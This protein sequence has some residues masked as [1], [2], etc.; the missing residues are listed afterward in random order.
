MFN[1]LLDQLNELRAK[2]NLS[3]PGSFEGLHKEVRGLFPVNF[4][5]DGAKFEL[6]S[7]HNRNFQTTHSF[8]WGSAQTPAGYHFGAMFA[9]NS[10]IM[11]G[12]VDNNGTLQARGHYNWIDLP[13]PAFPAHEDGP[14]VPN[15][16]DAP[17]VQSTSKLQ[18]QLTT[19]PGQSAI[20]LEHDH[21]GID[22]SIS[23]KAVN[24][25]P[26][27]VPS[28]SS[29]GTPTITGVFSLNYLQ[30]ISKS[31]SLGA[32][33][34]L[35]R[36]YP[37]MSE[38]ATSFALRYAPP[39]QVLPK[40][41]SLPDSITESP[42]M[43]INPSDPTE[44]ATATYSPSSG[45]AHLSYWRRLNQRLEVG[46]ELQMLLTPQSKGARRE[47][48]ATV[49][50]KFDTV[51]ATIRS[52]VETTGRVTTVLEEKIS[53]GISFQLNGEIDYAKGSAGRVGFG[54]TFEQ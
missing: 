44:V 39:A 31:F 5:I 47:A 53:P 3:Q 4:V 23:A 48:V 41:T 13:Q 34:T 54:F 50:F 16:E 6:H 26:F 46:S 17:K 8:S 52:A 1:A 36:P 40:P 42:Y 9:N 38:S 49:G 15:A 30:S 7:Q 18:A 19:Q 24:A 21:Q 20:V 32:E 22:Y 35:Q 11:H 51:F 43:P 33:W 37:D 2:A 25:N 12:L 27:D 45:M 10:M 14:I 29:P 28:T